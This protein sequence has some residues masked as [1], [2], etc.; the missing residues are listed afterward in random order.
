MTIK[1]NVPK[2]WTPDQA[3][4]VL[5]FLD[6]ICE[7]IWSEYQIEIVEQLKIDQNYEYDS[8]ID[9]DIDESDVPF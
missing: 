4:E 1:V 6:H 5:E 7:A 3:V 2:Y 9:I 8:D